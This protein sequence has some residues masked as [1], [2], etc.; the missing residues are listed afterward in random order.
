MTGITGIRSTSESVTFS[1]HC[2]AVRARC[3]FRVRQCEE[4]GVGDWVFTSALHQHQ[5]IINKEELH[6]RRASPLSKEG[7][8][9]GEDSPSVELEQWTRIARLDHRAR[10]YRALQSATPPYVRGHPRLTCPVSFPVIPV[11]YRGSLIS[12][13]ISVLAVLTAVL[14]G[15]VALAMNPVSPPKEFLGVTPQ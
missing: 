7:E 11:S 13:H 3:P 15:V 8:T 2:S 1:A 12:L 10:G 9:S 14:S 5:P 4:V 6:T